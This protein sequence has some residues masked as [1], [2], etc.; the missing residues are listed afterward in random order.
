[1]TNRF[2][3]RAWGTKH[4]KMYQ[5]DDDGL[6]F[7]L[8]YHELV[9]MLDIGDVDSV[10]VEGENLILMQ[11]TGL[12]DKNGKL[13]FEGDI[14]QNNYGPQAGH[15]EKGDYIITAVVEWG[16]GNCDCGDF[17]YGWNLGRAR[18]E[19]EFEIIGNIYENPDLLK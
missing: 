17:I 19:N 11:C 15:E 12:K 3:F 16:D 5:P 13:I 1:M 18:P 9:T 10:E 7:S 2:K 14:L 4:K 8:E 6:H